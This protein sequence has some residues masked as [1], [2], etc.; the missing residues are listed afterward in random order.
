MDIFNKVAVE[1]EEYHFIEAER[2]VEVGFIEQ[3]AYVDADADI[4]GT[5][6]CIMSRMYVIKA[7][8]ATSDLWNSVFRYFQ[9]NL[10]ALI[11]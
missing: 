9:A 1:C 10:D 8:T 11:S 2:A 5:I 3:A 4:I 6:R 7:F